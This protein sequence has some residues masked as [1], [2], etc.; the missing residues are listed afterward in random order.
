MKKRT[1]PTDLT[2][3]VQCAM[4]DFHKI[5]VTKHGRL[6]FH[7]HTPADFDRLTAW[8][9]LGGKPMG[10]YQFLER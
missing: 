2:I 5:S 6:V 1:Y 9:E 8:Y 4:N 3:R 10:C 7:N